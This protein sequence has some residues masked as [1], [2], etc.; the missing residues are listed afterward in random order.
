MPGAWATRRCW[1]SASTLRGSTVRQGTL[2]R[3]TIWLGVS[4]ITSSGKPSP[5]KSS[6]DKQQDSKGNVADCERRYRRKPAILKGPLKPRLHN[7]NHS[8]TSAEQTNN[9]LW[10]IGQIRRSHQLALVRP[11]TSSMSAMGIL[12]Q[13]RSTWCERSNVVGSTNHQFASTC[14][15]PRGHDTN[16]KASAGRQL[17]ETSLLAPPSTLVPQS[18]LVP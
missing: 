16:C 3:T 5:F 2:S 13:Q 4:A 8:V 15:A 9:L 18:T 14:T 17:S 11:A 7:E 12:R 1:Q 6:V 10:S